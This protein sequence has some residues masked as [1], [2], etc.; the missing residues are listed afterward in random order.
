MQKVAAPTRNFRRKPNSSQNIAYLVILIL[1]IAFFMTFGLKLILGV[2]QFIAG[3]SNSSDTTSQTKDDNIVIV[4]PELYDMPDATNS[5][6]LAIY[7]TSSGKGTVYIY[8]NDEKATEVSVDENNQDFNATIDLDKDSNQIYAEF[9][10]ENGKIK[11]SDTFTVRYFRERPE[12]TIDSPADGSTSQDQEITVSGK[13]SSD[14]QVKVNGQP[15]V[16]NADG[17][18]R[19]TV[20]LNEGDNTIF[21]IATDIAGNFEEKQLKVTYQKL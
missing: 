9:K 21:V 4:A 10:D 7:G 13:T 11:D 12:L 15:V 1:L 17:S 16:L 20:Q 3:F 5:A 2:S 8:V 6:Q 14:N 18:F 19:Q